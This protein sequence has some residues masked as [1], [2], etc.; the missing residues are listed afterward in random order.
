VLKLKL[1]TQPFVALI[2]KIIENHVTKRYIIMKEKVKISFCLSMYHIMKLYPVL[3]HYTTKMEISGQ[4]HALAALSLEKD[5][6]A[7]VG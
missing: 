5:Y 4:L 7:P 3:K 2:K 1:F 6:P